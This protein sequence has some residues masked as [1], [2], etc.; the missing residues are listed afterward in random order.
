MFSQNVFGLE[1]ATVR[2]REVR[3]G[4]AERRAARRRA[5]ENRTD[6]TA[7]DTADADNAEEDTAVNVTI[8][9]A[10]TPASPTT[11]EDG[12]LL[13]ASSTAPSPGMPSHPS[14]NTPITSEAT[15]A[16][17]E[18]I[19]LATAQMSPYTTFQQLSFA[20]KFPLATVADD[21]VIPP[22][23][24]SFLEYRGQ[25]EPEV[26]GAPSVDL[27]QVQFQFSPP[28]L[29]VPT[30]APPSKWFYCD[31]KGQIHG[32]YSLFRYSLRD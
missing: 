2:V 12:A 10:V 21:Y 23:Y 14:E 28:G 17:D 5:R 27:A 1:P 30:P 4:R 16:T 3:I 13:L 8:G 11:T 32:S 25:H 29:P 6:Q 19:T 26:N 18:L 9:V 24:L 31:P 7:N 20:P 22:T 15:N